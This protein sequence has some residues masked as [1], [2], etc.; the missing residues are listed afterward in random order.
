MSGQRPGVGANGQGVG[1]GSGSGSGG[2]GQ[3]NNVSGGV[4]VDVSVGCSPEWRGTWLWEV[5]LE[6]A[7]GGV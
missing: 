3:V 4:E 1:S 2:K 6:E 7:R 5:C